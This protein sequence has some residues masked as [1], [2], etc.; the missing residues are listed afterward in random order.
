MSSATELPNGNGGAIAL[1]VVCLTLATTA[2]LLRAYA[3]IFVVKKLHI[4]DFLGLCAFV[5][6]VVTIGCYFR[7]LRTVGFFVHQWD[8][9]EHGLIEMALIVFVMNIVYQ[10]NQLFVK[11]AILLEWARIFTPDHHRNFF[12]W[13]SRFL[14][15]ATTIGYS[16]GVLSTII[17]CVPPDP[18][19]QF[20]VPGKC[21]VQKNRVI[22][23]PTFN[24]VL[25][26]FILILPQRILWTLQ[27]NRRRKLCIAL[28]FSVGILACICASGRF[29]ALLYTNDSSYFTSL[30]FFWTITEQTCALLVFCVPSAPKA[31][32]PS[33]LRSPSPISGRPWT[34]LFS[35]SKNHQ[36]SQA[37]DSTRHLG[38]PGAR[39]DRSAPSS[40]RTY[41]TDEEAQTLGLTDFSGIRKTYTREPGNLGAGLHPHGGDE[42]SP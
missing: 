32:E 13:A 40:L 23:G 8:V 30:T 4:E 34:C 11:V 36:N 41:S 18:V 24:I 22:L 7:F 42:S 15:C 28:V 17:G 35:G 16:A 25:D 29:Q 27:M 9:Q 1:A 10:L 2:G 20:Y 31:F 3:R 19:W 26:I 39:W 38:I 21:F 5:C 33:D 37:T 12:F 14:V 6:Y